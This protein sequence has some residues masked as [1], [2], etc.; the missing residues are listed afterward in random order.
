ME[1]AKLQTKAHGSLNFKLP[2]YYYRGPTVHTGLI[3][4]MQDSHSII[5]DFRLWTRLRQASDCGLDCMHFAIPFN[6]PMTLS[7]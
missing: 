7:C 4:C 6:R 1:Q 5:L 2:I 3:P